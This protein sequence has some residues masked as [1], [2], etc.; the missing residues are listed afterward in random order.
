[1]RLLPTV[2]PLACSNE[3]FA[4]PRSPGIWAI[5]RIANG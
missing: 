4:L 3:P 5:A 1:M 2:V